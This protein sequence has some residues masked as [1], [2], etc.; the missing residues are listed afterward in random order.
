MGEE[1]GGEH[2]WVDAEFPA[3]GIFGYN[4]AA[5]QVCQYSILARE[6]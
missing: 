1:G 5:N 6:C 2:D 4:L 3:G